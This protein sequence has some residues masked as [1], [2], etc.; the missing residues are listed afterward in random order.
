MNHHPSP[1]VSIQF[2]KRHHFLKENYDPCI[3][4]QVRSDYRYEERS[5]VVWLPP[6]PLFCLE[7][8]LP[9]SVLPESALVTAAAMWHLPPSGQLPAQVC[10]VLAL[11]DLP[12]TPDTIGPPEAA[13]APAS[14]PPCLAAVLYLL[15]WILPSHLGVPQSSALSCLLSLPSLPYKSPPGPKDLNISIC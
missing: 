11:L 12:L 4:P 14:R 5:S 13:S 8:L 6:P 9:G 1:S 15:G 3:D 10:L 2:H 7:P